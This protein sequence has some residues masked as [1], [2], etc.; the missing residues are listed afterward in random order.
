MKINAKWLTGFVDGEGCFYVGI[1]KNPSLKLGWQVLPEFVIVQ[2]ECDVKLLYAIR[3]Y[4][5]CG[6]VRPNKGNGDSIMM[7]RVRSITHLL[8]KIIPFFERN[9]LITI[10]QYDFYKFRKILLIM[11]NG[12]HLTVEG[13]EEIK[14]LRNGMRRW[15]K[16]GLK[17]KEIVPSL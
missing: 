7:Y 9:R 5:D 17:D 3:K 14:K 4:F 12:G 10:K 2:H 15:K 1:Y 11:R 8:E 13:L 6:K 16:K